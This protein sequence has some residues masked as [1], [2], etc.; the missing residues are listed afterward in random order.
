[1]AGTLVLLFLV[2]VVHIAIMV[3]GRT[4]PSNPTVQMARADFATNTPQSIINTVSFKVKK[5]QGVKETF[6]NPESGIFIYTF[7]NRLN[8][9]ESILK[10]AILPNINASRYIPSEKEL[11]Q[12]CPAIDNKGFYGKL[13]NAISTAIN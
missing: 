10:S 4:V 5:C 12:G 9:S 8:N 13:T 1:M 6:Y 11:S 2:L 3:K 7:D